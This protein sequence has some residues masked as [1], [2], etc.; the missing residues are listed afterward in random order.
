MRK[1]ERRKEVR[2]PVMLGLLG[3]CKD[4]YSTLCEP[5]DYLQHLEQRKDV[6]DL[7]FEEV[8]P[9]IWVVWKDHS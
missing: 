2:Y 4:I 3:I 1:Q 5:G 7:H 9:D 8:T 6:I